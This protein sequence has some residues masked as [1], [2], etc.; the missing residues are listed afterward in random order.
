MKER[1]GRRTTRRGYCHIAS[2]G[3]QIRAINKNWYA[4]MESHMSYASMQSVI[5]HIE[6][7]VKFKHL[8]KYDLAVKEFSAALKFDPGNG[9]LHANLGDS[10]IEKE[11]FES[12]LEELKKAIICGFDKD[13][14]HRS[15][16]KAY[17]ALGQ[18][19]LVAEETIKYINMCP[20]KDDPFYK[21]VLLNEME[22]SQKKI[23]L[24]SKPRSLIVYL[25]N[26]CNLKCKMC[27]FAV[28]QKKQDISK[29]TV[30]EIINLF[31]YLQHI[32]WIGG[33]VFLSETLLRIA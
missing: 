2:L 10:Y 11:Y 26:R 13:W 32:Q 14:M 20:D 19:D 8:K 1:I 4:F 18:N 7:G 28:S 17:Y 21:N 25:T 24:K 29:K 3:L 15:M 12:G 31:P 23:V 22:I 27:P 30:K 16:S 5:N 33:D 9:E 6:N